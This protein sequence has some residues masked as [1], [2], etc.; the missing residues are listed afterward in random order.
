MKKKKLIIIIA[1]LVMIATLISCG[2]SKRGYIIRDD[3]KIDEIDYLYKSM[4]DDDL[5]AIFGLPIITNESW[6]TSYY[7]K[8][9]EA[10]LQIDF[11]A[12]GI[13]SSATLFGEKNITYI[14]LPEISQKTIDK[15]LYSLP[16][17]E[18]LSEEDISFVNYLTAISV[19][20]EK[21][22]APHGIKQFTN[23]TT[24]FVGN[25]FYY[26][27]KS[28]NLFV[29]IHTVKGLIGRAWIENRFGEEIEV[30]IEFS[31]L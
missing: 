19:L 11:H 24:R 1:L 22:G 31:N 10:T 15:N 5:F 17:K 6:K 12:D 2:Q 26:K 16:L 30:L 29:F 27:L 20:Q 3:I 18:N 25:A 13:I 7:Y 9:G 28:G 4:T 14:E 21:L 23:P 8:V